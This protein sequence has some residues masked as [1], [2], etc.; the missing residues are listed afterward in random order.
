MA[1]LQGKPGELRFTVEIKRAATGKVETFEMIGRV[2]ED[3][4][5]SLDSGPQRRN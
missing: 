3:G 2:Q 1:Q 4:G 5:D